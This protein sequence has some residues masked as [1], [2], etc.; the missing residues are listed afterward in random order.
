[1][2][3]PAIAVVTIVHGRADHLRRQRRTLAT[4]SPL[5]LVHVVVAMDDPDV[6]EHTQAAPIRTRVVDFPA[7]PAR[8]PLAAAR[9]AGAAAAIEEGAQTLVF[10]DVDCLPGPHLLA[11][12]HAASLERPDGLLAGPVGY[13]PPR[14]GAEYPADDG[15]L[16]RLAV[17][18]P[19]RPILA[20]NDLID[21]TGPEL[22]WSL[23]FATS[24]TAWLNTGGFCSEYAGYGAEDTDFAMTAAARGHRLVW[25]GNAWAWHQDHGPSGPIAEHAGDIVRNAN[26]FHARWASWPMSGWLDRLSAEGV[27]TRDGEGR[28]ALVT[29]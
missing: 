11:R 8:L 18:S 6:R 21:A 22:F 16:A 27:I 4:R 15:E 19:S 20:P 10:L 29:G 14:R 9:N 17:P 1:M 7:D 13:L 3:I 2:T 25:V 28:P 23:S 24:R 26:V 12:Y 5:P